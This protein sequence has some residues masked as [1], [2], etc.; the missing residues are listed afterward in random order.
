MINWIKQT[1]SESNTHES[2]SIKRQ[3]L[4]WS[5]LLTTVLCSASFILNR[6]LPTSVLTL[7][8]TLLGVSGVSY[9]ISR[10]AETKDG[11]EK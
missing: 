9:T 5:V 3:I 8:Q 1:L 6:E 10:F 7:L 4:A 11:D 2:P